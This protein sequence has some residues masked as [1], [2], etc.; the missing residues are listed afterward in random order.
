MNKYR[1]RPVLIEAVR[2]D[3]TRRYMPEVLGELREMGAEIDAFTDGLDRP[4]VVIHTLE[5]NMVCEPGDWII[6]GVE[7]E[8][9]PCKDSIFR[10]TYE[11]G[12]DG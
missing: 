8:F 12:L 11:V 6:R 9:Y 3:P 2:Y 7:G 10:K 4:F 1:K 5:G